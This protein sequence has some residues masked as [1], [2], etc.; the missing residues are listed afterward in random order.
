[1]QL[2]RRQLIRLTLH[3]TALLVFALSTISLSC[4][5]NDHICAGSFRI[6]HSG[7]TN[8]Q[9]L[10]IGLAA[11]RWNA[12]M[13]SDIAYIS[14]SGVCPISALTHSEFAKHDIPVN[15]MPHIAYYRNNAILID[16]SY[17]PEDHNRY[18]TVII[19]EMGHSFGLFHTSSPAIMSSAVS[20]L[21][22]TSLD[23]IECVRVG[24]CKGNDL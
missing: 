5:Y 10:Y 6:V 12:F 13:R 18:I 11:N 9:E 3:N 21:D 14:D 2:V 16:S 24:F 8:E 7:F 15:G 4:G 17:A 22:F 1:M 19:H 20:S 23:V